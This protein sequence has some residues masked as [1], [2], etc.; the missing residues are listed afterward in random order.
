MEVKRMSKSK[1]HV[2]T[3][4]NDEGLIRL[5]NAIILQ[6]VKDYR[7]ALKMLKKHPHSVVAQGTK[8]EIE[9]FFYSPLYEMLTTVDPDILIRKLNEE[10]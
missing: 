4:Y 5:G 2:N 10:V 8:T 6:A 3:C 1:K 7:K 9:H